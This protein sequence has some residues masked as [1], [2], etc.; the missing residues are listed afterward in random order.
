MFYIDNLDIH[1]DVERFY[2]RLPEILTEMD[3]EHDVFR[4]GNGVR[5]IIV[6]D[7]NTLCLAWHLHGDLPDIW[8][9]KAA[10]LPDYFYFDNCPYELNDKTLI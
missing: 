4:V 10:Y 5:N 8:H 7:E 1:G 9:L 6:R 2:N 3:I